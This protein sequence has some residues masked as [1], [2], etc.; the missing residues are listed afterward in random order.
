M[1]ESGKL[2]ETKGEMV[3]DSL[4]CQPKPAAPAA[5]A[6]AGE[7]SFAG[8]EGLPRREVDTRSR[9]LWQLWGMEA[10]AYEHTSS[11]HPIQIW[12]IHVCLYLYPVHHIAALQR[13]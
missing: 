4:K 2:E 5:V 13:Q 3:W 1:R 8:G 10:P 6:S 7:E 9:R 11:K 12:L